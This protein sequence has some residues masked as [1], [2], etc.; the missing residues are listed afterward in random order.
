VSVASYGLGR[1]RNSSAAK[2][3]QMVEN[4][5]GLDESDLRTALSH[6]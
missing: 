1:R 4:K 2:R 3:A 6:F 5:D